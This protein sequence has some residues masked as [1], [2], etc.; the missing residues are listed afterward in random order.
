M[1]VFNLRAGLIEDYQ[2]Y[3]ESFIHVADER[4]RGKVEGELDGGLLWPEPLVQL[5]PSFESGGFVDDLV[6]EG[7]LHPECSNIFRV[8][9]ESAPAA[10]A[11]GATA[12]AT[13]PAAAPGA[14]APAPA[15]AA[16]GKPLRL[17]R[18]QTDAVRAAATGANYV[19]TTGTGSGKSLAYIIPIVDHVLRGGGCRPS[20]STP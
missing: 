16:A 10:A 14:P 9:K 11:L 2:N 12:T 18:H 7:L 20:S 13:A 6:A 3:V 4:I 17:H 19:L 5:N 8:G 15:P 1:D